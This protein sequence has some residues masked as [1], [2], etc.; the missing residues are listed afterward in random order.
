MNVFTRIAA[1]AAALVAV[2]AV[3]AWV[4]GTFG[5]EPDSPVSHSPSTSEHLP[6]H[7][8]AGR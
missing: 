2:F 5:P 1:F 4:G 6:A 7:G 3:S 8:E